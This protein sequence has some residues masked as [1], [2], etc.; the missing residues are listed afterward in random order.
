V[1]LTDVNTICAGLRKKDELVFP[2]W[3]T[4]KR[5]PKDH[6]RTQRPDTGS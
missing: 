5:V 1:K 4:G 2:D 6:Y 3:E